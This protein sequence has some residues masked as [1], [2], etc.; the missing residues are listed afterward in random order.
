MPELP[1]VQTVID[2]LKP[3]IIDH[4]IV[5]VFTNYPNI[6]EQDDESF[7]LKVRNQTIKEIQR[8]GKFIIVRLSRGFIIIHLRMEGKFY[9]VDSTSDWM[10]YKHS[11]VFFHL[12]QDLVWIYNDVR[13]FGT[14]AFVENLH[15]HS[16][17]N[18][19]G[20]D[21][22]DPGLTADYLYQKSIS[23]SIPIKTFLLDQSVI[24]GIGN[25]Y[26][27]ELLF[28]IQLSPTQPANTIKKVECER[29]V[30]EL[31]HLMTSAIK[32]GGTTIRSYTSSLGVTGLFQ[33]SLSVHGREHK[34]CQR[35][36]STIKR[37]KI[38][39]RSSFYC[40]QCQ[41]SKLRKGR[42]V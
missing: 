10:T 17:L 14:I 26:A 33:L 6:F 30:E 34:P 8:K 40:E 38:A 27:N 12:D 20:F 4:T 15:D 3:L 9:V 41:K 19:L 22:F 39:G 24:A 42:S 36:Q 18:R 23:R 11:H 21:V 13:K 28:N 37:I 16:G 2:T 7:R 25:I 32:Q 5:D 31:R 29:L 35:C 1:E